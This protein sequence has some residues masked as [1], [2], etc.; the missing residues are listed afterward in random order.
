MCNMALGSTRTEHV[1]CTGLRSVF[2]RSSEEVEASVTN[3]TV[4]SS[5][6]WSSTFPHLFCLL[7]LILHCDPQLHAVL[8]TSK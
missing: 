6:K 7:S 5:V 2:S 1:P 4:D 8:I 3:R